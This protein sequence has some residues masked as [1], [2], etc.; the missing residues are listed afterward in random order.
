MV[1]RIYSELYSQGILTEVTKPGR[2][3]TIPNRAGT[4]SE[5]DFIVSAVETYMENKTK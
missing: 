1:R 5:F 3:G 4:G 2:A